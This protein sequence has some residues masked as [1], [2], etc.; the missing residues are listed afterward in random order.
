MKKL[1]LLICFFIPMH[2]QTILV[3]GG[4]TGWIGQKFVNIIRELGHNPVCAESRLENRESII[5]EI[6]AVKPHAIINAAGITGKP[7]VDWCEE[8]KQETID[9]NVIGTLNLAHIAFTRNIH[10]TNI[11]T[12]CIYEYD[13]EHPTHSGRGFTEDEDPNFDGSFYS[14]TKI[15]MEKLLLVY[16]VLNLR[17]KMPISYELDKGFVGKIIT[18]KKLI[19]IPNSLSVLDD[20]LPI[21]VDMTLKEIKGNYNFVNPGAMSHNDVMELY[22]KYIDPEHIYENFS[23]EEQ[24]KILKARRANAELSCA[25]LQKLY[26]NI[27]HI[28][29]SLTQLF[30]NMAQKK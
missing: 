3:F 5:K 18:Y 24:A 12:G 13:S 14:R 15:A 9:T 2:A 29:D 19:N 21:A 16:P 26:P 23:L 25:K 10:L 11:S 4:K 6:E 7:N 28:K 17:I 22:K 8:H 1:S 30:I 27:P 20:L